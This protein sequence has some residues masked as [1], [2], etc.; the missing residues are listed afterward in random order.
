MQWKRK[1]TSG[2]KEKDRKKKVVF[3]HLVLEAIREKIGGKCQK[4]K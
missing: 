4:V 1:V 2:E 3:F